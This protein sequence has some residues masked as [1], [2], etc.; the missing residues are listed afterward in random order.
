MDFE[1]I[2]GRLEDQSTSSNTGATDGSTENEEKQ[3]LPIKQSCFRLAEDSDVTIRVH[4]YDCLSSTDTVTEIRNFEVNRHVL[5]AYSPVLGAMLTKKQYIESQSP[6]VNLHED[7]GA[8]VSAIGAVFGALYSNHMTLLRGP[9]EELK[10]H[11]PGHGVVYKITPLHLLELIWCAWPRRNPSFLRRL[12]D[13][14]DPRVFEP[15]NLRSWLDHHSDE[16]ADYTRTMR[17]FPK[18][19]VKYN[20]IG[21]VIRQMNDLFD[22]SD[23][24]ENSDEERG[25]SM[26]LMKFARLE[27]QLIEST[28]QHNPNG[29]YIDSEDKSQAWPH[30]PQEGDVVTITRFQLMT[31]ICMWLCWQTEGSDNLLAKVFWCSVART[32]FGADKHPNPTTYFYLQFDQIEAIIGKVL[33][34]GTAYRLEWVVT[35][36]LFLARRLHEH[37]E[38]GMLENKGEYTWAYDVPIEELP[39]VLIAVDKYQ[40]PLNIMFLWFEEWFRLKFPRVQSE[41]MEGVSIRDLAILLLAAEKFDHAQAF[42]TVSQRLIRIGQTGLSIQSP[43]SLLVEQFPDLEHLITLDSR[44]VDCLYMKPPLGIDDAHF[45]YEFENGGLC[46]DCYKG[47]LCYPL[48]SITESRDLKLWRERHFKIQA[49]T[50]IHRNDRKSRYNLGCR[51]K[52]GQGAW[53]RSWIG[54]LVDVESR[55]DDILDEV[56]KYY[57]KELVFPN[58]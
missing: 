42:W 33:G 25:T 1:N 44:I 3:L 41:G 50:R 29:L 35:L 5:A 19:A 48:R 38:P 57:P 18:I 32:H 37:S 13:S 4:E 23:N 28:G 2:K 36:F 7:T 46:I 10:R 40:V 24:E 54:P 56:S 20:Q 12:F 21:S 53:T 26:D 31:C 39:A 34:T 9:E 15:D 52:H 17:P 8:S 43:L 58:Y 47:S 27:E 51:V 14:D 16:T 45:S 30:L 11:R 55:R 49:R 22:D 6:I